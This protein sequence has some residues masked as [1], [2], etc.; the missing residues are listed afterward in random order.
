VEL[1][2][3]PEAEVR[4]LG[5]EGLTGKKSGWG[6]RGTGLRREAARVGEAYGTARTGLEK[7]HNTLRQRVLR[8]GEG[9]GQE[10]EEQRPKGQGWE[11]EGKRQGKRGTPRRHLQGESLDREGKDL[12][13]PERDGGRDQKS[14]KAPGPD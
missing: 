6:G 12:G 13:S 1:S 11:N 7:S 3:R 2:L 14:E 9:K 4:Y 5:A 8:Y 10:W